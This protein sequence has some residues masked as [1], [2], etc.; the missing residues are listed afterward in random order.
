MKVFRKGNAAE[1]VKNARIG[2]RSKIIAEMISNLYFF[3]Y[4]FSFVRRGRCAL[5]ALA[6]T[7]SPR[8]FCFGVHI[9][10]QENQKFM[11]NKILSMFV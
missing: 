11:Q 2:K 6:V 8:L 10:R 1:K 7:L 5:F 9:L 4:S 3:F